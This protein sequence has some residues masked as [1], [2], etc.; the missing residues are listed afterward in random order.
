MMVTLWCSEAIIEYVRTKRNLVFLIVIFVTVF[1]S[2]FFSM[3]SSRRMISGYIAFFATIK[4]SQH[5]L[6]IIRKSEPMKKNGKG[7]FVTL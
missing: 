6:A 4:K 3:F 5:L 2:C 7:F 1:I